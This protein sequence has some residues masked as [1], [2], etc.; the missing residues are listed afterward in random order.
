MA[1]SRADSSLDENREMK[2]SATIADRFSC[3]GVGDSGVSLAAC[4]MFQANERCSHL[5][6]VR[7]L[8]IC[9]T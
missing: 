4:E 6:G 8:V 9:G 7:A 2:D 3:R 5:K 1:L